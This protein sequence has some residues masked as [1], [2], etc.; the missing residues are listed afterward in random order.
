MGSGRA[1]KDGFFR[2]RA[3]KTLWALEAAP[4]KLWNAVF[5]DW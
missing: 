4:L 2:R 3:R 5:G 1:P